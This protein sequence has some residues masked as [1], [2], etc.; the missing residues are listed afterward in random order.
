MCRAEDLPDCIS[1]A[2]AAREGREGGVLPEQLRRLV[3]AGR[4][5]DDGDGDRND[6]AVSS[7]R[8]LRGASSSVAAAASAR[9][10]HG[11]SNGTGF[12]RTALAALVSAAL[13]VLSGGLFSPQHPGPQLRELRMWVV[14]VVPAL[15]MAAMAC[16]T[17]KNLLARP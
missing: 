16:L 8:H 5:N 7:V 4:D 9:G 14:R 1:A 13:A 6:S 12:I 11:G 3:G 15:V 17:C 10:L 2:L